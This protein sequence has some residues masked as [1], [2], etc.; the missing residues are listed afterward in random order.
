MK[1]LPR[2]IN[3]WFLSVLVL[4]SCQSKQSPPA[5]HGPELQELAQL[6]EALHKDADKARVNQVAKELEHKLV[7]YSVTHKRDTVAAACLYKAAR[8]N[9]TYLQR[10]EEAFGQYESITASYPDSRFAPVALFKKGLLMET[11]FHKSD[12]A[13][14]YLDEFLRKYPEHKLAPMAMDLVKSAGVD[15]DALFERIQQGVAK[16]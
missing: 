7:S 6:E 15:A 16:P 1:M 11:Y 9:E 8:I 4:A 5:N 13:I 12:K 14:Y 3:S 10:N 2:R